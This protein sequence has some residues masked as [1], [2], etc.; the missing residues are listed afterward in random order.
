MSKKQS[1]ISHIEELRLRILYSLAGVAIATI[2]SFFFREAILELIRSPLSGDLVFIAPHEAFFVSLKAS[3]LAGILVSSPFTF[4]QVWRFVGTALKNNEK[5]FIFLYVPVTVL[6]F[7]TGVFFGFTL[8]LPIGL[9][10]LLNFAGRALIPMITIEKYV[11]FVFMLSMVFGLA[12]QL[13]LVMRIITSLGIVEKSRLKTGRRYAVVVIFIIAAILTPPDVFTQ[14]ALAGPIL[15]LYE[16]G[17]VFSAK[18]KNK[19]DLKG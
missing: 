8:V 19:K 7:L 11:S 2:I 9:D 1:F 3:L 14:V 12:F 18:D 6:L 15:I 5:K 13:P 17:I 10:F 4:Y 16:I